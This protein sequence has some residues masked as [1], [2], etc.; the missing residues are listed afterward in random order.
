MEA[1]DL[2][3]RIDAC[4]LR[5]TMTSGE[6]FDVEKPEFINVADTT[7]NVLVNRTGKKRNVLLALLNIAA[8][9]SLSESAT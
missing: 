9:E 1:D 8:V 3:A 7:A 2:L 5:I 6:T 4:P